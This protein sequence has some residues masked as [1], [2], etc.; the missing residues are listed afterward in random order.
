MQSGALQNHPI[1][2]FISGNRVALKHDP[3]RTGSNV[4]R[5][6][7]HYCCGVDGQRLSFHVH[8]NHFY[9]PTPTACRCRPRLKVGSGHFSSLH[10]VVCPSLFEPNLSGLAFQ[11]NHNIDLLPACQRVRVHAGVLERMEGLRQGERQAD[12]RL[13]CC[14]DG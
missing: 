2:T 12:E 14:E 13:V 11:V 1:M 3:G 4:N 8:L 9:L 10:L 6:A 5:P 7:K